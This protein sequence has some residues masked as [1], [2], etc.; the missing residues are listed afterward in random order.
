MDTNTLHPRSHILSVEACS[1]NYSLICYTLI[2]MK[3]IAYTVFSL[4]IGSHFPIWANDSKI[5][6]PRWKITCPDFVIALVHVNCHLP[7]W[8]STSENDL[9]A[10]NV[11]LPLVSEQVLKE[12][13]LYE[14]NISYIYW[15]C[16]LH[17]TTIPNFITGI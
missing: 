13:L 3:N 14:F 10:G 17:V 1:F 9:P 8:V 6:L 7:N 4:R 11:S 15:H 2:N 5:N 16:K 12:T